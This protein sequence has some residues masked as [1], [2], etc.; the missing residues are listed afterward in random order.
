MAV[1]GV[2]GTGGASPVITAE[3]VITV[4]T[5]RSMPAVM[6]MKVTPSASTPLTAVASKMPTMFSGVAK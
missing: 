5:E 1:S 6:M 2:N 3:S 4:P